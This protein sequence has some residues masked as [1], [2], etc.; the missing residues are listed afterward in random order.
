MT[1]FDVGVAALALLLGLAGLRTL[2]TL[3][4]REWQD[5]RAEKRMDATRLAPAEY[6]I[7]I[8]GVVARK[9]FG[10]PE[11]VGGRKAS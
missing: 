6:R 4:W 1:P 3:A 10:L 2:L 7:M 11:N 5:H 8:R 9:G